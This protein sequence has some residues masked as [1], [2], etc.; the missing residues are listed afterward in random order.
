MSKLTPETWDPSLSLDI[1]QLTLD[2]HRLDDEI[3]SHGSWVAWTLAERLGQAGDKGEARWACL[4]MALACQCQV[5]K[6]WPKSPDD[7]VRERFREGLAEAQARLRDSCPPDIRLANAPDP[8][9]LYQTLERYTQSVDEEV[10]REIAFLQCVVEDCS[11]SSVLSQLVTTSLAL[12]LRSPHLLFGPRATHLLPAFEESSREERS[13]APIEIT[14][15]FDGLIAGMAK[16]MTECVASN[17]ASVRERPR[18]L[19]FK[20]LLTPRLTPFEAA[21][22]DDEATEDAWGEESEAPLLRRSRPWPMR[23]AP[24]AATAAAAAVL[25]QFIDLSL[26]PPTAEAV[27]QPAPI[28]PHYLSYPEDMAQLEATLAAYHQA[29]SPEAKS[30]FVRGGANMLP[31]LS[32]YYR[33]QPAEPAFALLQ[34]E[35]GTVQKAGQL[36]YYGSLL[37]R[38]TTESPFVAERVGERF[39]ID[40]RAS[41]GDGA[42]PWEKFMATKPRQPVRMRVRGQIDEMPRADSS[43]WVCLCMSDAA[44]TL[45]LYG[46]AAQK[47]PV[48]QSLLAL[49][50]DKP[51]GHR[52]TLDLA[53]DARSKHADEVRI[54]RLVR[55]DWIDDNP[56]AQAKYPQ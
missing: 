54:V 33:S 45:T 44:D 10:G 6:A 32:A 42:M 17:L 40:W 52:L 34:P 50:R 3:I 38:D 29:T 25:A 36:F 53:W 15:R 27:N 56:T 16:I 18:P 22:N 8:L 21:K 26:R 47:Q 14:Q 7:I 20:P 11:R 35:V 4:G 39:L 24:W 12:L 9:R 48:G 43:Q 19:P 31:A 51:N 1:V 37:R 30:H 5:L 49:L 13:Q 41:T 23:L 46:Y 55:A 28:T 2:L